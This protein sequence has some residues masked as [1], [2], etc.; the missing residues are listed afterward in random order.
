[1]DEL[2]KTERKIRRK[3]FEPEKKDGT[4]RMR[5]N[6]DQYREVEKIPNSYVQ[7]IEVKSTSQK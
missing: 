5:E 3:I 4:W 6:K 7:K 2:D 1:M